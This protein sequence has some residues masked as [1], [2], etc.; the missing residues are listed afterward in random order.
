MTSEHR[1]DG[2]VHI[3][4]EG[5]KM[6]GTLNFRLQVLLLLPTSTLGRGYAALAWRRD[7]AYRAIDRGQIHPLVP[8]ESWGLGRRGRGGT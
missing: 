3:V 5:P 1:E 6:P 2:S 8:R 7:P 4:Q